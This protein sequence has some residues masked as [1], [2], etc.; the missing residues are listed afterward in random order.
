MTS[1]QPIDLTIN[2]STQ[3]KAKKSGEEKTNPGEKSPPQHVDADKILERVEKSKLSGEVETS[4][5]KEKGLAEKSEAYKRYMKLIMKAEFH[6]PSVHIGNVHFNATSDDLEKLF[7]RCGCI[8]RATVR[9]GKNFK[10]KGSAF[11]QFADEATLN[12][13][14]QMDGVMLMGRKLVVCF[15][16]I[17]NYKTLSNSS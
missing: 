6:G 12:K 3:Q 1:K 16:S 8:I 9:R 4:D 7:Q 14:M 13:A 11:I 2:S 15:Q 17:S 5:A 10:P